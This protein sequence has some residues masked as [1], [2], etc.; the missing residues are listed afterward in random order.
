MRNLQRAGARRAVKAARDA[1]RDARQASEQRFT[2]SL[3][4]AQ[5]LRPVIGRPQVAQ[6]LEGR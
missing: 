1:R 2:S 6:G 3:F 4:F 5:R